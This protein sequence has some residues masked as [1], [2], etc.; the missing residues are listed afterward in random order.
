[1]ISRIVSRLNLLCIKKI[2][3]KINR[4][5]RRFIGRVNVDKRKKAQKLNLMRKEFIT[6]MI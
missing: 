3:Y 5:F 6:F 1:M 4:Y 2:F